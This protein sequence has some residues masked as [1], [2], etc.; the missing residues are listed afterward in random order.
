MKILRAEAMGLCF[1]VRDALQLAALQPRPE[2]VT[3]HGELV[4]N[5]LVL[6]DLRRRGF[7]LSAETRRE[8]VPAT[9]AVLVTAHGISDRER[10]RLVE[11]GKTLI[12]TTC[13]LV[14]RAHD[15][16]KALSD[17]GYFVLVIGKP[18]HVE[19]RGLIG[20]LRAYQV[21]ASVEDVLCYPE[22]RLGVVCQTTTQQSVAAEIVAAIEARN[23]QAEIRVVDTVCEPTKQRIRAIAQLT[24]Q[25]DVIV[26]VGG[27]NSNNT[28]Q[29]ARLSRARGVP[30][31]HVQGPDD[32][33]PAWLKDVHTV[34][35]TA[36]TST[37]DPTVD[38]VEAALRRI[39]L[40]RD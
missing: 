33:D 38:V 9:A 23:P 5:E 11:R 30:A 15:A 20:D 32:L 24:Q 40:E 4:H 36:G 26:V 17:Q 19:V 14:R 16:A 29:L 37:L 27:A 22:P 1:G 3:I 2:E 34:G 7:Q 39:A 12:D 8:E 25:A 35:L 18:G 21:L 10:A 13:P 6:A 28:A 31:Y